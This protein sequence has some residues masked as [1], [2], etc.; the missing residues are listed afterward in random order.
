MNHTF[1][2]IDVCALL[3]ISEGHLATEPWMKM[4]GAHSGNE[5][6]HIQLGKSMFF[7]E[8]EGRP[9][10]EASAEAHFK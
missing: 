3:I 10:T 1:S 8:F 7:R 4:Y 5:V 9:F 2:K 6:Y